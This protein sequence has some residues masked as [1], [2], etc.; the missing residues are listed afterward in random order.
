LSQAED[1]VHRIGQNNTVTIQYLIA[2][3]TADDYI[4]P[5]LNKKKDILNAVGLKQDLSINNIDIAVQNSK[6]QDLTSFLNISA[7]S[8]SQLQLDM[9]IS[10]TISEVS[11]SNIKELLEVDDECFDSCDWDNM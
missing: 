11:P 4:W 6:Q 2:Q 5:L 10:P 3:N 9:E 7:S 1:R 8:G